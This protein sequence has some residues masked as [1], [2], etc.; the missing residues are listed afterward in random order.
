MTCGWFFAARRAAWLIFSTS[1]ADFW[2]VIGEFREFRW[3]TLTEC[4]A[5][6]R[7]DQALPRASPTRDPKVYIETDGE[8]VG[9]LPAEITVV[10]DA[11][12]LAGASA[13][14]HCN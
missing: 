12:D 5:L 1:R 6:T 10:P 7:K 3:R 14:N 8:L 4:R 13:I 2:G 9:T 11:L